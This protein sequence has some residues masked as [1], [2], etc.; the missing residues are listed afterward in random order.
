MET[1]LPPGY[2][3]EI[4]SFSKN[5]STLNMSVQGIVPASLTS[6]AGYEQFQPHASSEVYW[7]TGKIEVLLILDNT[8][9]M[10]QHNRMTE[11]K[12]AAKALLDELAGSEEGLVKVGMVPFDVNVRI[13]TTYQTASWFKSAWWVPWFWNGCITDRD[14]PYDVSDAAVTSSSSTKYPPAV[15]TSSSLAT[16]QPLTD[17]LSTLYTKID[18]MTP[19][20]NTNITI[21]LAWGLALLSDQVPFTEAEPWGTEDL[22]KIIVLITDG[23]NT[24]NRWTSNTN[25]INARTELACESANDAGVTLYAIRLQEGNGDLL[26]D[27]ATSAD[28][29][30]DVEDVQ[31]LVPTF[32]AIGEQISQ[33]RIAH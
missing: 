31:D 7:G 21:G 17:N 28:T 29:Y 12:K 15:C 19:A 23:D 20:G 18:Q 11:L 4:T 14:Q 30:Y 8:G 2:N 27:C 10:A 25:S 6:F 1:M 26:S 16:I 5:G 22:S 13:P 32:Q 33:L 9:S 24:E 3:F